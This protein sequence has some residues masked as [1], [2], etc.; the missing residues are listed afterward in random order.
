M[1]LVAY[2][3]V[4]TEKQGDAYGPDA[5]LAE[6]RRWAKAHGHKIVTV[7]QDAISGTTD[8][9]ERPGLSEALDQLR[10]P[11]KATGLIVARLDRLARALHIQESILQVAW[12]ADAT[13]F[14]ADAGE[15]LQDDEDDPMRTFVRQVIG[16]A[17]QLERSL[18]TKRMR[19]GR[20]AKAAAGKHAVGIYPFGYTGVG[21]GRDRDA[22]PHPHEQN[23][24]RRIFE[25][26]KAEFTYRA[27][28]STLDS[29][30]LKPRRAQQWS[31]MS[32]RAV[33]EREQGKQ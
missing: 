13:V 5:Q 2:L 29:E 14:T 20:K 25:L 31:A 22:A 17:A 4:S 23:I 11:P 3:R 12:R 21:T 7:C 28:A 16:G 19:D 9:S 1:D 8:P 32:V 10:P 6:I 26:R 30:G 15:V 24:V 27:I 18:I 33:V